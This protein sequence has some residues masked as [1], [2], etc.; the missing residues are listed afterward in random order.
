MAAHNDN[1]SPEETARPR[2]ITTFYLEPEAFFSDSQNLDRLLNGEI[3]GFK[4]PRSLVHY[5]RFQTELESPHPHAVTMRMARRCALS[6]RA[7]ARVDKID[8]DGDDWVPAEKFGPT[9]EN[10]TKLFNSLTVSPAYRAW[11]AERT[12]ALVQ[13]LAANKYFQK[14]VAQWPDTPSYVYAHYAETISR[15]HQSIFS[16]DIA[17]EHKIRVQEESVARAGTRLTRG[18][19]MSPRPGDKIHEI[20]LNTHPDT[21][22]HVPATGL[23]VIFHEN[24]HAVHTMLATAFIDGH[25][26]EGHPLH[27]DARLL[28]LAS[29]ERHSYI[30]GI[31]EIYRAHPTEEDTFRASAAFVREL[32]A[33]LAP[34]GLTLHPQRDTKPAPGPQP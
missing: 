29:R 5:R 30:P 34:H 33:A 9:A 27:D 12:T 32:D 3:E 26:P 16:K 25:L 15:H 1:D 7:M 4:P 21:G 19:H 22:F 11:Q 6:I 8:F 14:M 2:R 24:T 23:D 18:S 31:K 10:L 28:L 17:P 20:T 13:M